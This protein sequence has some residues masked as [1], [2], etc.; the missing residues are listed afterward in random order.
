MLCVLEP[1]FLC[2]V[3]SQ[4]TFLELVTTG[5]LEG[6][7]DDPGGVSEVEVGAV[8]VLGV[9]EGWTPMWCQS[10]IVIIFADVS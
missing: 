8:D 1:G 2:S 4:P 5:E 9:H 10:Y 6:R 7:S 3:P